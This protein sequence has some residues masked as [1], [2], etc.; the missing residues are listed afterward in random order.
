ITLI[1]LPLPI[2]CVPLLFFFT[3][4]AT[5]E[6]YTLSLHDALP[7]L[8]LE[9]DVQLHAPGDYHPMAQAREEFERLWSNAE[10]VSYSL[11]YEVFAD[12]SRLRYGLYRV[13]EASGL[14]TF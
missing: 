1:A 2:S 4:T 8:N 3:A 9:T 5:T 6:I 10:G 14:S 13:M 7:I 11:D 12:H